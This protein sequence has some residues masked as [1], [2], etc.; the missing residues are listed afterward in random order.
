MSCLRR[1]VHFFQV[2]SPQPLLC[3]GI[4]SSLRLREASIL[5]ALF[6]SVSSIYCHDTPCAS[7]LLCKNNRAWHGTTLTELFLEKTF[8]NQ[9]ASPIIFQIPRQSNAR[10]T[11]DEEAPLRGCLFWDALMC[12]AWWKWGAAE[13]C[14]LSLCP[15]VALTGTCSAFAGCQLKVF[16]L[17]CSNLASLPCWLL[18]YIC[19]CPCK[20]QTCLCFYQS[21]ILDSHL[22]KQWCSCLLSVEQNTW[23]A[24]GRCSLQWKIPW[25]H[26]HWF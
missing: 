22:V 17:N 5:S 19:L 25:I 3:A 18:K 20:S 1:K 10:L 11:Y 13:R 23:W 16:M 7:H 2:L 21:A 8:G 4:I 9:F 26:T 24:V 12:I 15:G 6:M 14:F